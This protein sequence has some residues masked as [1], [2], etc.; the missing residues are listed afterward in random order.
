MCGE[1]SDS[2][3][4]S[5]PTGGSSPHVRGT[6]AQKCLLC[7]IPRFIP[8]CAGN[9]SSDR[10]QGIYHTVHPRMCGERGIY[11]IKTTTSSGSSPHVRGTSFQPPSDFSYTR[12]IP[13]CAGNVTRVRKGFLSLTVHPRMCGERGLKTGKSR[14]EDGSS[15]HVRGTLKPSDRL[16][17]PIRFIPACAGNVQG[18]SGAALGKPVH[19]RMCG[20][21]G[22][23]SAARSNT[24]GSSPHVRG[25]CHTS[26]RSSHE[27]RFIPACAGNVL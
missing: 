21:R 18:A 5:F 3:N 6:S 13:A 23:T 12:F 9:V 10:L 11:S 14:K 8:A 20:E 22:P 19:P 25:T 4:L 27:T 1:R 16:L 24:R 26:H 15:P 17:I 7:N 2:T